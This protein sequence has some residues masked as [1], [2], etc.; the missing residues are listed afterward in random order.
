MMNPSS[1]THATSIADVSSSGYGPLGHGRWSITC[2]C[3]WRTTTD[4]GGRNAAAI[5]SSDHVEHANGHHRR[6]V[7]GCRDCGR[8][9]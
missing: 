6:P 5:A 2:V 9:S 4:T 7:Y 1:A 3:G 8:S